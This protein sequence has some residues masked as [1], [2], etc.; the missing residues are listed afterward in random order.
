MLRLAEF[1]SQYENADQQEW[2]F[3]QTVGEVFH[4]PCGLP[5]K[6]EFPS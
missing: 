3:I 2:D 1:V 6:G 5:C 4:I